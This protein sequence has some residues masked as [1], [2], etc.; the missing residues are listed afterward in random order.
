MQTPD[1]RDELT[2]ADAV[3]ELLDELPSSE[4]D[5][6]LEREFQELAQWLLEAYLYRRRQQDKAG[7][8]EID[9]GHQDSTI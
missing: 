8:C 3:S 2:A 7:G 6:E 5:P 1:Q 9:T 4:E